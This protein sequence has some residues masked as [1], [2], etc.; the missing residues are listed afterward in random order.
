MGTQN[1]SRFFLGANAATGFY[2]LYDGFARPED[3]DFLWVIKGGPGCGKST[4]MKRLGAAMEEVGLDVEYIHCSGDPDSLDGVYF[5]DLHI[6]YADG[7]APHVLDPRYPGAAGL[8]LD[9]G[10]F[11]N[12]AAL[13]AQKETIVDL[14]RRYKAL[15]ARAYETL[16]AAGGLRPARYPGITSALEKTAVL[17]R[18]AGAV[19]R[20]LKKKGAGT[21]RIRRR[22]LSAITCQ[23]SVFLEETLTAL[24]PRIYT[25]DN[26][27]GLAPVYIEEVAR[28]ASERNYD[29]CLCP[30]P[31]HPDT[32]EAVLIPE[33]GLAFL[34]ITARRGF[35][36]TP[37]RHVRLD[38]M[39]DAGTVRALRPQLRSAGRLYASLLQESIQTLGEAKALHD[40][41][42]AHILWLLEQ[43]NQ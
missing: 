20:E 24:C 43:K 37:Y 13:A 5:P 10:A 18:A 23:G 12:S 35:Q 19:S 33:A 1:I 9:L 25:L 3:G 38:A 4:F 26:E 30:D 8:Y 11:Y 27:Y 32:P 15:Y 6:G 40:T 17:R 7:T 42:S 29:I 14:N 31:L 28:Q 16:Q 36:G 34:A 21:G 22:F 39:A 41:A 2:S